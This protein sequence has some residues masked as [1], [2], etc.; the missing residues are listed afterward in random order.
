M[1]KDYLNLLQDLKKCLEKQKKN[2]FMEHFIQLQLMLLDF[3][4]ENIQNIC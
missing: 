2:L 1:K 3:Y 4:Q